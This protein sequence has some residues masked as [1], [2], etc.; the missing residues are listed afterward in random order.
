MRPIGIAGVLTALCLLFS[1]TSQETHA[2]GQIVGGWSANGV[3]NFS[4]ETVRLVNKEKVTVATVSRS[5]VARLVDI[6]ANVQRQ[7]GITAE[8]YIVK[9]DDNRRNAFALSKDGRNIVGITPEMLELIEDDLDAY[10]AIFGHEIAHI[11]KQHGV[12]RAGRKG[13]LEGVGTIVGVIIGARTGIN[14]GRLGAEIIDTA[15][16]RDEEREADKLGFDYMVSAGFNPHGAVRA[17]EK[18]LAANKIHP[19]PFLSTH[20]GGEERIANYQKLIAAMP[21]GARPATSPTTVA[22]TSIYPRAEP[23]PSSSENESDSKKPVETVQ[24]PSPPA[25]PTSDLKPPEQ[26]RPTPEQSKANPS[27]DMSRAPLAIPLSQAASATNSRIVIKTE[28]LR[29]QTIDVKI[30]GQRVASMDGDQVYSGVFASGNI[31]IT[32]P[33]GKAEFN[34]EANKEYTFEVALVPSTSGFIMFG[35]VGSSSMATYSITLKETRVTSTQQLTEQSK[36]PPQVQPGSI[37][38][39]KIPEKPA[40]SPTSI[41]SADSDIQTAQRLVVAEP[42]NVRAWRELARQYQAA[43]E[44]DKAIRA[45]QEALRLEPND[46]NTLEAVGMLYSKSGQ[47]D[48]LRE[49]WESLAKVDKTRADKFFAAYILP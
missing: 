25:Q 34:A 26:I 45:Y 42:T 22:S 48:K 31:I 7:A 44:A 10:A 38:A 3:A 41:A 13:F 4:S 40:N 36:Q 24:L 46:A 30:N 29:G 21:S 14:P 27:N 2:A 37:S 43:G 11:V 35:L 17:Y 8:L 5:R 6:L 16:S 12:N 47:K 23:A 9:Y 49:V 1:A 32:V 19:I 39:A 20:P 18:M 33:G 15:F 28:P